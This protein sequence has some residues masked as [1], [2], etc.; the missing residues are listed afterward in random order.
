MSKIKLFEPIYSLD[1]INIIKK[2]I[3]SGF[4]ASGSGIGYVKKFEEQFKKYVK[5]NDCV[6]VNSGTAALHL[7][8]SMKD[9]K[10]KEVIVPSLSFASTAHSILYNG[11]KAVFVDVDPKTLCMNSKELEKKISKKTSVILPV[12]FGGIPCN[13]NEI[14]KIAQDHGISVIDDAAHACGA[15]YDKKKIGGIC[16]MSCFSFHP[17]KNLAMPTG[18]LISINSKNSKNIKKIL[19]SRRWCG[20][21]NRIKSKY[22]VKE[23]GWNFYM[24][25]F[26]AAIGLIQLKKLDKL[27][28]LRKRVAKRYYEELNLEY[29]MPFSNDSSYHFYWIQVPNRESFRKKLFKKGIETGFH[30]PPIHK[31]T[32]YKQSEKLPVTEKVASNIVTLPTHPNLTNED[33]DEIINSV[34]KII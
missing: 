26:S 24:N 10:Q 1:E 21:V 14:S 6:C 3:Q 29:K 17:V 7:A 23:L 31:M 2:V 5:S 30:Y 8:L 34:N 13:L 19:N 12:H 11:G 16:E 9:I 22:D 27:N 20:I 28:K 32:L 25:E 33:V 18:G 4:W 15:I